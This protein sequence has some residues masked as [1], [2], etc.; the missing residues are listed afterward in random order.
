MSISAEPIAVAETSRHREGGPGS[1]RPAFWTAAVS[2]GAVTLAL[3]S[4][5]RDRGP[6]RRAQARVLVCDSGDLHLLDHF[7]EAGVI[8]LPL[9]NEY[10]SLAEAG[11]AFD[12]LLEQDRYK[13]REL[14]LFPSDSSRVK[15]TRMTIDRKTGRFLAQPRGHLELE[16]EANLDEYDVLSIRFGA[17]VAGRVRIAWRAPGQTRYLRDKQV[18]SRLPAKELRTYNLYMGGRRPLP[19]AKSLWSAGYR[20][21]RRE[22]HQAGPSGSGQWK[23]KLGP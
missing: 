1:T 4:G 12:A 21:T 17:D 13:P 15:L 2:M 10:P 23:G 18:V 3:A 11:S 9:Y 6:H 22:W 7:D 16:A 20:E 14:K 8:D 19:I 5:C